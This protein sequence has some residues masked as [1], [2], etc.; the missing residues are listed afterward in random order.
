MRLDASLQSGKRFDLALEQHIAAGDERLWIRQVQFHEQ[1]AQPI[2]LHDA[3]AH[4]DGAQER[5]RKSTRLNSSHTVIS[6]AVFCLKKKTRELS[7]EVI[8]ASGSSA[9]RSFLLI[10]V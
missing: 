6:Y 3:A 5:D 9:A 4:V 2:H 8:G 1:R 7:P 10:R